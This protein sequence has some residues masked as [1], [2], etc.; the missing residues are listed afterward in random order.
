M[1]KVKSG[2]T[3]FLVFGYGPLILHKSDY[4]YCCVGYFSAMIQQ[5]RV[6]SSG[7]RPAS[8]VLIHAKEVSQFCF[9][10]VVFFHHQE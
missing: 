3:S 7:L 4:C 8:D 2:P 6:P 10:Y 9:C 5:P 1:Q